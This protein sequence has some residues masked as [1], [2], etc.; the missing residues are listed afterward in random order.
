MNIQLFGRA[1]LNHTIFTAAYAAYEDVVLPMF[2]PETVAIEWTNYT[3]HPWQTA[4]AI[5][6]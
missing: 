5:V 4:G 2:I 3:A 6:E 1:V